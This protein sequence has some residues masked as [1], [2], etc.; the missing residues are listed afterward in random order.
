MNPT[1]DEVIAKARRLFPSSPLADL[2]AALQLS[3]GDLGRLREAM[4]L[5]R[6]DYKEAIARVTPSTC[7]PVGWR[8][9]GGTE[10]PHCAYF[11]SCRDAVRH[12]V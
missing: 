10:R 3:D 12:L 8:R 11:R 5:A 6:T 2:F 9:V 1:R 4:A 7:D